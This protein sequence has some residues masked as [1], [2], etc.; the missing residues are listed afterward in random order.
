M[1][2]KNYLVL[3]VAV[4]AI[5]ALTILFVPGLSDTIEREMLTFLSTNAR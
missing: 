5:V 1:K 3:C 2:T 4:S